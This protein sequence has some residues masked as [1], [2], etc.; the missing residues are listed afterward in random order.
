MSAIVTTDAQRIALVKSSA[1]TSA[2]NAVAGVEQLVGA[3]ARN[4]AWLSTGNS[5]WFPEPP[6]FLLPNKSVAVQFSTDQRDAWANT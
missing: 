4:I 6:N 2:K 1:A 5:K 3:G